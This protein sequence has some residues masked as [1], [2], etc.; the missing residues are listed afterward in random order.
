M[1]EELL[2][3]PQSELMAGRMF[4]AAVLDDCDAQRTAR[5]RFLARDLLAEI[6]G[7]KTTSAALGVA[8]DHLRQCLD[9]VTIHVVS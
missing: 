5:I 7:F 3:P 9:W 8:G 6:E 1:R 4:A 2:A